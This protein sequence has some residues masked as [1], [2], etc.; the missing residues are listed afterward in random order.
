MDGAVELPRGERIRRIHAGEQPAAGQHLALGVGDA[1]P[2]AQ[3]L[4]QHRDE[5]GVA[6]LAALALFHPQRHALAVDVADLQ[7][8][9]F[10]G[11]QAAP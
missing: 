10:A 8:D 11:A 9:D 6:V 7:G 2:G 1:P 4:Q 5:H 3:A